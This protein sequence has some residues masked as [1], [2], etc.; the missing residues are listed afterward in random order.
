[1]PLAILLSSIVAIAFIGGILFS[2]D[3]SREFME[4]G[5][6]VNPATRQ[7]DHGNGVIPPEPTGLAS[8]T[9]TTEDKQREDVETALI[10]TC[11]TISTLSHSNNC[12]DWTT[13]SQMWDFVKVGGLSTGSLDQVFTGASSA[14]FGCATATRNSFARGLMQKALPSS[15][16]TGKGYRYNLN[17]L[18]DT[19]TDPCGYI[20]IVGK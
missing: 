6:T 17:G 9:L 5:T 11:R 18:D 8:A 15:D 20:D 16:I 1:M 14:V 4:E 13:S 2:T 10:R 3:Q 7:L 19:F 12:G